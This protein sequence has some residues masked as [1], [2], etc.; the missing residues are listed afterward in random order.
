MQFKNIIIADDHPIVRLGVESF[1]KQFDGTIHI[2]FA[3]DYRDLLFVLA[4]RKHDLLIQDVYFGEK[5]ARDFISDV[6]EKF[7]IPV[8]AISTD[9]NPNLVKTLLDRGVRAFV[10]KS[11][12]LEELVEALKT[13]AAGEIFTSAEIKKKLSKYEQDWKSVRLTKRELEVLQE[14]VKERTNKEIAA[15]LFISEKTVEIHKTNLY[16]KL[17]VKNLAG[18][19]NKAYELNLVRR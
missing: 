14:A 7:Q 2:D 11:E 6:I 1:V 10:S 3:S 17:G 15:A 18:L 19:V 13:V 12:N 9:D 5:D 16:T 8:I 4:E